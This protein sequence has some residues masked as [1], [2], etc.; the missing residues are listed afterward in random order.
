MYYAH[1]I[2]VCIMV[3]QKCQH[4]GFSNVMIV[5]CFQTGAIQVMHVL[6]CISHGPTTAQPISIIPSHQGR[7]PTNDAVYYMYHVMNVCV[8]YIRVPY[9]YC[10]YISS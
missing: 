7:P 4:A 6:R 9:R 8:Q 5:V 10:M 2:H 3:H 1:A